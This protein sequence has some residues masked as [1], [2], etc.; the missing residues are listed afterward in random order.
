MAYLD[1]YPNACPHDRRYNHIHLAEEFAQQQDPGDEGSQGFFSGRHVC[2]C[3]SHGKTLPTPIQHIAMTRLNEASACRQGHCIYG[4]SHPGISFVHCVKRWGFWA[5]GFEFGWVP[6][7][8]VIYWAT[9]FVGFGLPM[10]NISF[11]NQ[12]SLES[13]IGPGFNIQY[14]SRFPKL[15]PKVILYGDF[16]WVRL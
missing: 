6:D 7:F 15:E 2:C 5:P 12:N 14:A 8:A 1:T 4:A 10:S 3:Y 9:D 13:G 16:L 11:Q